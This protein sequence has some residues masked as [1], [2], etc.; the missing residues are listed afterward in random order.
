MKIG[1]ITFHCA[2]NYGAVLQTAALY[3]KLSELFGSEEIFIVNYRPESILKYYRLI[4]FTDCKNMIFVIRRIVSSIIR[5]PFS[6]IRNYKFYSF[7]KRYFRYINVQNINNLDFLV[8]G[9]DQIWNPLITDGLDPY[10]FG[11]INGFNGKIISYAASDGG[12]I[13]FDAINIK[14][15]L[16]NIL[17]ISVREKT[18]IPIL[19]KYH[20][21]DIKVMVDPVFLPSILYWKGIASKQKY[22][23]YILIYRLHSND[24]LYKDA[25]E[26]AMKENKKIIEICYAY[27]YKKLFMKNYTPLTYVGLNEFVSL[28]LYADYILTNSFH[29]MA[30][31]I[32]MNK[33]FYVYAYRDNSNNRIIDLLVDLNL[34]DRY[35]EKCGRILYKKINYDLI[36]SNCERKRKEAVIFLNIMRKEYLIT[37]PPPPKDLM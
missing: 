32:I 12:K 11:Q 6:I 37:P 5:L 13:E 23:N 14:S 26:I 8:C 36:N 18:M 17:Y 31:S 27:P 28:F 34:R 20:N 24:T 16:R 29:G 25:E 35:V 33:E 30:F 10:Y 21:D 7:R 1:I 9:S 3:Q 22:R 19:E 2:N 15:L 4:N